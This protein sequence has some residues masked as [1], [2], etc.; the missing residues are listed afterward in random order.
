M[1]LLLILGA[2]VSC[3]KDREYNL[4]PSVNVANDVVLSGQ[5][6][7]HPFRMVLKAVNDPVLA[8]NF[9]DTI[10]KALV[11]WDT[12]ENKYK[13]VYFSVL[14]PDSVVRYGSFEAYLSGPIGDP[15][16]LI[17]IF[18]PN[19]L[20]DSHLIDGWD[21]I[22]ND[23]PDQQGRLVFANYIL[24]G[25]IHKDSLIIRWDATYRYLVDPAM[26]APGADVTYCIRGEAEG[27][28][29]KGYPFSA[30]I[31]DSLV[32]TFSCPWILSGTIDLLIPVAD[33]QTG[34]IDYLPGDGCTNR[35]K[36]DFEGNIYYIRQNHEYLGN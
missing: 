33:I 9:V 2:A 23:G 3:Q 14:C 35:I 1:A 12:A 15:G 7:T 4:S 8:V 13:F 28:S 29:S 26:L 11:T 16:T 22:V 36:Y 25:L 17:R 21:S 34:T 24:N 31:R 19:Y 30:T 27:I 10:D 20:E 32:T 6:F 5:A 18:F